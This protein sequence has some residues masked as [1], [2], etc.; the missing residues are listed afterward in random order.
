MSS[1]RIAEDPGPLS[2]LDSEQRDRAVIAN[3][4][5]PVLIVDVAGRIIWASPA[6]RALGLDPSASVGRS[7]FEGIHSNDAERFQHALS[8]A[9]GSRGKA[10]TI[11]AVHRIAGSGSQGSF[12]ERLT[13]L[14]DT[15]GIRGVLI[16]AREVSERQVYAGPAAITG[17]KSRIE[18]ESEQGA[19]FTADAT[20]RVAQDIT[21]PIRTELAL[22]Q[23]QER[24]QQVLQVYDIG[25]FE[26]DHISGALYWS[27]E[28]RRT[29]RLKPDQEPGVEVFRSAIH[30]E[31]LKRVQLAVEKAHD[32]AGDGRYAV[33][34]RITGSD[35]ELRWMDARSQTFFEGE[36]KA[37]RP[38]RTVGAVM[39]ITER[40]RIDEAL[41]VS[42][43]SLREAQ[44]IANI[45]DWEL[46]YATDRVIWSDEIFRVFEID[47]KTF[48]VSY[49]SF[50]SCVHPED[51]ERVDAA[52]SHSWIHHTPYQITHRI[53]TPSGQVKHIEERAQ[54]EFGPDGKPRYWRG[55]SQDVTERVAAEVALRESLQEKETLLREIHHRVK[56]NL[57]IIAS[58]LHFQAKRV[59]DPADLAAFTDCRNRLGAMIL[60]H[61][62]LY[63]SRD[64]SSIDFGNYLRSLVRDLQHSHSVGGRRL[65]I[66]VSTE[67]VALPIQL[68]V[69]CGMIV[70]E[71][72]TN[73]FKYAFPAGT[74]GGAEVSLAATGTRVRL[75][76]SD[77][78]VGLPPTFDPLHG[79]S[80]GWQLI[81]NLTKQIGGEINIDRD[82]GT[83][84]TIAFTN[85]SE[86]AAA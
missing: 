33:Q 15:P 14:P 69:P 47:P 62:K 54:T 48:A 65:D 3:L 44:R 59:R 86:A 79:S 55:T 53:L 58:L 67:P 78:G 64:L 5:D 1:D 50:L 49:Q 22:R 23:S 85:N 76:V 29:W 57:Q 80:F 61:E 32:P 37:R 21:E 71:L 45:G 51:R 7:V 16:L 70:C 6:A 41:R 19:V 18:A 60:V 31:D 40:R 77:N 42:E 11:R 24:L 10:F 8:S 73:V 84:V 46:D 39:D 26:H 74:T 9:I 63:Q 27:P 75:C 52:C 34:F 81:H 68:A 2:L 4:P 82:G 28:L 56:N 20:G 36:G 35:G 30:E 43:R 13:Y 17:N 66:Q 25:I 83:R 72:L 12:D 38:V